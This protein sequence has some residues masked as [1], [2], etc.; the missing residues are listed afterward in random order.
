M[1]FV[2][3]YDVRLMEWKACS[4]VD[5]SKCEN[6]H[7]CVRGHISLMVYLPHPATPASFDWTDPLQL[8]GQLSDAERMVRDEVRKYCQEKLRPR[9]LMA[10]RN[11]HFDP[12]IMREMGVYASFI[13]VVAVTAG[14][15]ESSCLLSSSRSSCPSRS[16][17]P[18]EALII[19]TPSIHPLW[20]YPSHSLHPARAFFQ[21]KKIMH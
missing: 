10:N 5:H 18:K 3:A 2:Y 1:S 16:A 6:I 17:F 11:E 13:L 21:R 14:P 15:L 7:T 9:V 4:P 19:T 12:T 8:E 20:H